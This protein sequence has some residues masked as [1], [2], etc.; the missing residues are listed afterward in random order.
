MARYRGALV[1]GMRFAIRIAGESGRHTP[2]FASL[3][4]LPV[5]WLSDITYTFLLFSWSDTLLVFVY[6]LDHPEGLECYPCCYLC[7]I[8]IMSRT[9]VL[10]G[11][12]LLFISGA[13]LLSV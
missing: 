6:V 5:P 11:M 13:Y 8:I 4:F 10:L 3:V 12:V 1:P 7:E 9:W 2:V